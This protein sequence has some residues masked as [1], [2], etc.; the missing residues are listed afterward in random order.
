MEADKGRDYK[1][2]RAELDE[3]LEKM[4]SDELDVDEALA[5]FERGQ[6][7]IRAMKDYLKTVENKIVR[8]GKEG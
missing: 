6:E 7:L 1:S 8:R 3:L 5:S 2:M 4:R